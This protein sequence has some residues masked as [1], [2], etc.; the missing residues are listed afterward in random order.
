MAKLLIAQSKALAK[1]GGE[2]NVYLSGLLL[3]AAVEMDPDNEDAVFALEL[4]KLDMAE[5]DWE[6]ITDG[7]KRKP[8]K[9]GE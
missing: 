2:D 4:Y 9:K 7:M 5:I 1:L 6:P 3:A 8:I